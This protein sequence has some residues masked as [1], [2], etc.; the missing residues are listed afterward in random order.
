MSIYALDRL[1][2]EPHHGADTAG[3]RWDRPPWRGPT[4]EPGT[5]GE[6]HRRRGCHRAGRTG[7]FEDPDQGT[8]D[9]GRAQGRPA[10]RP[11]K[12]W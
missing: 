8:V 9:P 12:P 7:G 6:T 4:A 1:I 10:H 2:S 11:G 5:T 3:N